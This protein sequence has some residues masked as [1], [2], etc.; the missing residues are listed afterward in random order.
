MLY[1]MWITCN[2]D[3]Q[4]MHFISGGPHCVISRYH[5]KVVSLFD[6]CR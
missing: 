3:P 1:K 5:E 4:S 6:G 2:A